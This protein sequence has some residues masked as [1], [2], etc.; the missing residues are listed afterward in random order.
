MVRYDQK[1]LQRKGFYISTMA[2]FGWLWSTDCG[3]HGRGPRF[4]P[5]CAHQRSLASR[6]TA[7]Q[8]SPQA[9]AGDASDRKNPHRDDRAERG[10]AADGPPGGIGDIVLGNE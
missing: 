2:G 4:D 6:A 1:S 7:G 9:A 3:S 5:L 10:Q 8:A